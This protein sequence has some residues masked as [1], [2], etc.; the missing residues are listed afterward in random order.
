MSYYC[1]NLSKQ[2]SKKYHDASTAN[3][4]LLRSEA[5]VEQMC[6]CLQQTPEVC[7][8]SHQM[9][10]SG[11]RV[12]HL[13]TCQSRG[14]ILVMT[15]AISTIDCVMFVFVACLIVGGFSTAVLPELNWMI[16][17]K[18]LKNIL[19][20]N[21]HKLKKN[22]KKVEGQMKSEEKDNMYLYISLIPFST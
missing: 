20:A 19:L 4:M 16:D 7:I 8:I 10:Q 3:T 11:Q 12:A 15:L 14:R 21:T 1:L 13:C 6:T 22:W 17:W 2:V 18:S 9:Q 5:S